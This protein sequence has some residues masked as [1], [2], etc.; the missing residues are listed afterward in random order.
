M[1]G[2]IPLRNGFC[3]GGENEIQKDK[4]ENV[5]YN[6]SGHFAGDGS[7]YFCQYAVEQRYY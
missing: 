5:N 3:K 4:Y 6:Y 7:T 1:S 2:I